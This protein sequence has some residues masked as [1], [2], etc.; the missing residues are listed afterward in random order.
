L[1]V[2]G[3]RKF[4]FLITLKEPGLA[5]ATMMTLITNDTV[6]EYLKANPKL[7]FKF[8]P[9]PLSVCQFTTPKSSL[10]LSINSA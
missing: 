7:A 8:L 10:I 1:S 2:L 5:P 9:V 6:P 3:N 4:L